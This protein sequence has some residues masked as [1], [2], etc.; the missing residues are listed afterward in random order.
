LAELEPFASA[1]S[2]ARNLADDA[3]VQEMSKIASYF[4]CWTD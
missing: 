4:E 3:L 2:P 1:Q